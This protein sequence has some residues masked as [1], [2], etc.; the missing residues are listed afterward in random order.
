MTTLSALK[1]SAME[2]ASIKHQQTGVKRNAECLDEAELRYDDT[3]IY[4]VFTPI[5]NAQLVGLRRMAWAERNFL[6]FERLQSIHDEEVQVGNAA[7]ESDNDPFNAVCDHWLYAIELGKKYREHYLTI[8]KTRGA[9]NVLISCGLET[10]AQMDHFIKLAGESDKQGIDM[11]IL[12]LN[13]L[14]R[15]FNNAFNKGTHVCMCKE[16]TCCCRV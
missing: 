2:C 12:R 5:Q 16:K 7:M 11:S 15:E 13:S 9:A 1:Q 10:Q 4:P 3:R 8:C 14:I 6:G